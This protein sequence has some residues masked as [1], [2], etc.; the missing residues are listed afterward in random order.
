MFEDCCAHFNDED[1]PE[2]DDPAEYV[3]RDPLQEKIYLHQEASPNYQEIGVGNIIELQINPQ[4]Y[5]LAEFDVFPSYDVYDFD[6]ES[7]DAEP[8]QSQSQE[9]AQEEEAHQEVNKEAL[10]HE[11]HIS[12]GEQ[13]QETPL[14]YDSY[15]SEEDEMA[16]DVQREWFTSKWRVGF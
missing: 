10:V 14:I 16:T 11:V 3:C 8:Q 12:L 4:R 2:V 1:I 9:V 5:Y 15:Y 13:V 7:S 6:G